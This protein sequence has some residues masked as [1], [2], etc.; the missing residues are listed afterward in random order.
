MEII[1]MF[2]KTKLTKTLGALGICC[3]SSM[4]FAGG[5]DMPHHDLYSG[6]FGV[7][8]Q[9]NLHSGGSW[10]GIRGSYTTD[11]LTASLDFSAIHISNNHKLYPGSSKS[12]EV[13]FD[14]QAGLRDR[15]GMTNVFFTYGGGVGVAFL[16]SKGANLQDPWYIG[17]FAGLDYQ[18]TRN[19]MISGSIYPISYARDPFKQKVWS[20]F[21]DGSLSL[22]YIF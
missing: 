17:P 21:G 6:G 10:F 13:G 5:P 8:M 11:E 19:F 9:Y 2:M 18:P 16:S 12:W 15:L 4:A 3:L 7:G 22:N 1:N 14:G 20:F